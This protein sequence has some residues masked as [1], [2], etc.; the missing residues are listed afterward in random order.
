MTENMQTMLEYQKLDIA[1]RKMNVEYNN[2]PDKKRLDAA[3][4]KFNEVQANLNAGSA[5]SETLAAE[6]ERVYA[7]F[8]TT[9]KTLETLEK[10]FAAAENDEEKAKFLPRLESLKSRL[11]SCRNKIASRIDRIKR[12]SAEAVKSLDTRKTVREEFDKTKKKLEEYK[13]QVKPEREKIE[14][15]MKALGEKIDKDLLERYAKARSEGVA[16]PIYVAVAGDENSYAC[17]V[18]GM[19]LSQTSKS[20]LKSKG[21]CQCETCRRLVYLR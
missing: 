3:R 20:E 13:D 10:E 7:E 16:V 18:C 2:H 9:L 21:I 8:K 19:V 6:I 4:S 14:G 5:E 12:I 15:Q 1:L 17:G 11:D